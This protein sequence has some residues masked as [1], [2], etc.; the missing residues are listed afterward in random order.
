M[1]SIRKNYRKALDSGRKSGGGRIVATFFDIC[2]E[3]WSGSLA[4]EAI[5]MGIESLD[6]L[7]HAES[8]SVSSENVL[9]EDNLSVED[10]FEQEEGAN[11]LEDEQQ[12]EESTEADISVKSAEPTTSAKGPQ[13][14]MKEFLQNRRNKKITKKVSFEQQLLNINQEELIF[15]K[16]MVGRMDKQ[17]QHFNRSMDRLQ[18]NMEMLT[19]TISSAFQTITTL[20]IAGTNTQAPP[21][22]NQFTPPPTPNNYMQS[23]SSIFESQGTQY[24]R[25]TPSPNAG[26]LISNLQRNSNE[27]EENINENDKIYYNL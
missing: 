4:T 5:S 8:S 27:N 19:N 12:L 26:P 7:D 23:N 11:N 15:K 10:N 9:A 17:D 6:G 13:E 18:N 22:F 20:M 1:K 2:G 25:F 16:D 24:S 3:I 14:K 21:R